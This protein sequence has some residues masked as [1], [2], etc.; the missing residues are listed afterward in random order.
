MLPRR[1]NETHNQHGHRRHDHLLVVRARLRVLV[2]ARAVPVRGR[3]R[4]HV[5]MTFVVE[6]YAGPYAG[7]ETVQAED[8]A[9]AIAIVKARVRKRMSLSMYADGYKVVEAREC[10]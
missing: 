7:K 1:E 9:Q 4:G 5:R 3:L 10:I 2:A 8:E 6:F